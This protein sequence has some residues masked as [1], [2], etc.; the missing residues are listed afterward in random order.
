[1]LAIPLIWVLA[2]GVALSADMFI[3]PEEEA[4]AVLSTV[5]SAFGEHA[6]SATQLIRIAAMF[7]GE[8]QMGIGIVS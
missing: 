6:E 1:M 4:A 7:A 3:E 5:E 2:E 8:G